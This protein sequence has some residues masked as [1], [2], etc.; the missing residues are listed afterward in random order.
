MC[1]V[2]VLTIHK[3]C[4]QAGDGPENGHKDEQRTV[5]LP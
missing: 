3:R 2:L 1:S 5:S 4:G